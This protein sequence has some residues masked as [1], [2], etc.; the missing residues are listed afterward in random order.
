MLMI[1]VAG[2]KGVR[3]ILTLFVTALAVLYLLVPL[4]IAGY[5]PI[6]IALGI[7]AVLTL[8]TFVLIT[9]FSFKVVSGVLGTLGGLAAVGVLSVISQH[10]LV[11][12]GL[13]QEFGFLELGIA[14]WRTPGIASLEFHRHPLRRH[15]PRCCRRDDGREYVH[16]LKRA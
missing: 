2:M 7:A 16:L 10:A 15:H 6:A 14:L 4:T 12:T 5:N 9:G 1:L 8:T 3:A 13:A 11:L